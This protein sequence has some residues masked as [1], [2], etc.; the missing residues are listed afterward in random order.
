MRPPDRT[1]DELDEGA[2]EDFRI[3]AGDHELAAWELR[4]DGE[5]RHPVFLIAHGWGASYGTI[6]RLGEP[7]A[8]AGYEVVLFDVRGHGRNEQL[9]YVT[10]RDFRDDVAAA[11]RHMRQRFPDR[12]IVLVGHSLGGAG[13]VLAIA[14]GAVVDGLVLIATPAD[15][16]RIT[17]GT[18]P[19]TACPADSS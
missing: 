6:L 18:S 13:A 2:Y 19:T 8:E 17:A 1:I 14:D 16:M 7:L 12:P 5:P 11:L 4:P 15:V 9:P 10:V 3:P